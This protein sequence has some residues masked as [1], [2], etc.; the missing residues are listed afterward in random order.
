SPSLASRVLDLI[1]VGPFSSK[2]NKIAVIAELVVFRNGCGHAG[3]DSRR[4]SPGIVQRKDVIQ[5][6]RTAGIV[7][8]CSSRSWRFELQHALE[9]SGRQGDGTREHRAFGSG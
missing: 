9:T 3:F 6:R 1:A 4:K 8:P 7:M 2:R 5:P